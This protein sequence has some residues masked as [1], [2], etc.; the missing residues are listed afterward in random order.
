MLNGS[1]AKYYGMQRSTAFRRID[2]DD[3]FP[4]V[5]TAVNYDDFKTGQWLHWDEN[6]PVTMLEARRAQGVP[7]DEVLVG[8]RRAQWKLTGNGVSRHV[9]R[10]LGVSL[11]Q[12]YFGV[13]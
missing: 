7:D 13:P 10:A 2:P 11:C 3:V 1:R 9:A 8:S 5:M 12:A 6:R 4:T